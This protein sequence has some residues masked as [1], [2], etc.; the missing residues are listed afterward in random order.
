MSLNGKTVIVTGSSGG[1]GKVT[2]E[3]YLSKGC[4]VV[5]CDINH[6]RLSAAASELEASYKDKVLSVDVDVTSEE[7]VK[8][9]VA[10]TTEKFGKLDIVVNNAG[11][12]D[13]FDPAGTCDK[14]TWDRVLG[15]NLTG[16]FLVTK[17]AVQA[18]E[19]QG[20]GLIVNIGSNASFRGFSAG[21][22]YTASKHAVVGITKNTAAFYGPKGIYSFALLLGGMETTNINEGF[23]TGLNMEGMGRFQETNPGF[24]QGETGLSTEHVARYIGFL[25]E[26][27][28]SESSN[29]SCIVFNK[30]WPAA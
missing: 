26:D 30:N 20:S 13:H 5:V 27:G 9:L 3:M 19:K 23:A 6:D 17:H 11:I 4:N 12:V 14:S 24:V 22:A 7:S 28:M 16:P 8:K 15:V 21:V 18:M 10:S 2:A 25:S 1:L 29:G